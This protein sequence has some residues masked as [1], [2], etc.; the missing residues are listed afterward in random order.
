MQGPGRWVFFI[1]LEK[2]VS[3]LARRVT[4]G[5]GKSMEVRTQHV[6]GLGWF[7][8]LVCVTPGQLWLV[9]PQSRYI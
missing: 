6:S 5:S 8:I 4:A 2:C 9:N 3:L 1:L 7:L